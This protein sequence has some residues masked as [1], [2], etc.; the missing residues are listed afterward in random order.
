MGFD[1]INNEPKIPETDKEPRYVGP[2]I[3]TAVKMTPRKFASSVLEV[4]QEL[5]GTSWL[6]QEAILDPKAFLSLLSK[7][8]PK[9]MQ[10]DD[11]T[12]FEVN[13]VDQFGGRI[14]I[15]KRNATEV[16]HVQRRSGQPLIATSGNP[17]P[18]DNSSSLRE[19]STETVIGVDI[20]IKEEF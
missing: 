9:S 11:L 18:S 13:I 8:I 7:L 4:Y 20:D 19:S 6:L 17:A 3:K 10:I 5:G 15:N 2:N 16:P 14:E 12:G 1:F